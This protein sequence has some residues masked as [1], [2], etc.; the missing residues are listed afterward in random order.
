MK[1]RHSKNKRAVEPLV[2][3]TEIE[4]IGEYIDDQGIIRFSLSG[5]DVSRAEINITLNHPVTGESVVS[6][7]PLI[8]PTS[9]AYLQQL[10]DVERL[11]AKEELERANLLLETDAALLEKLSKVI[12]YKQGS[13]STVVN[14]PMTS[15]IHTQVLLFRVKKIWSE[16]DLAER[17]RDVSYVPD[18][19]RDVIKFGRLN[20]RK[21]QVMYLADT[22]R[23]AMQEVRLEKGD[24]FYLSLFVNTDP[25]NL[26]NIG[27]Q[28]ES[29]GR[30]GAIEKK[31]SEFLLSEF[32][33][34]V[35]SG[36]EFEYRISN[37]IAKH[38]YSY[39]IDEL[40][41]WIYPSIARE[42]AMNIALD[43]K[44]TDKKIKFLVAFYGEQISE[45]DFT[46]ENP[47]I[48]RVED[49]RLVEL[50]TILNTEEI[51]QYDSNDLIAIERFWSTFG[52]GS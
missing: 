8:M 30:Y 48:Q 45:T 49:D 22:Y 2:C 32:T 41:G 9:E 33:K 23:T 44:A 52:V 20:N 37:L 11:H 25:L 12:A 1:R 7:E 36:K 21:E 3:S 40:D 26:M 47:L 19:K 29:E 6:S 16:S 15:N 27:E 17:V 4:S 42:G 13:I 50:K 18:E 31:V 38:Y 51:K 39:T 43:K 10:E 34:V 35:E 28:L 5:A 14:R 24:R 46:L